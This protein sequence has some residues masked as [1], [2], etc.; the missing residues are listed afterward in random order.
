MR[1][2]HETDLLK[3]RVCSKLGWTFG[4]QPERRPIVGEALCVRLVS[5]RI[6]I[7]LGRRLCGGSIAPDGGAGGAGVG[8]DEGLLI[9][10]DRC[11]AGLDPTA[12]ASPSRAPP[13]IWRG[14][15]E[16]RALGR[17]SAWVRMNSQ[18]WS[19]GGTAPAGVRTHLDTGPVAPSRSIQPAVPTQSRVGVGIGSRGSGLTDHGRRVAGGGR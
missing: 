17:H 6:P 4:P 13:P 19:G 9:D 16:R 3:T 8:L 2:G 14:G 11:G 12:V 15:G 18:G 5:P 1:V 10:P 7:R